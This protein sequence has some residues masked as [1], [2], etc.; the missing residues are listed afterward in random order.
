[1]KRDVKCE[2]NNKFTIEASAAGVEMVVLELCD[3]N[4]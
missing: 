4:V 1:M 3:V 2:R